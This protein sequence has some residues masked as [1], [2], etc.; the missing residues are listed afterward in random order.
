MSSELLALAKELAGVTSTLAKASHNR[1]TSL[2]DYL[3]KIADCITRTHAALT[4]GE[5]PHEACAELDVYLRKTEDI[6]KDMLPESD[7]KRIYLQLLEVV[8]IRGGE[9]SRMS[10]QFIS[11]DPLDSNE[12]IELQQAAGNLRGL[13]NVLRAPEPFREKWRRFLSRLRRVWDGIT[14]R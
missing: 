10:G 9:I 14:S 8:S 12:L 13:A 1:R 2:A 3:E 7:R 5:K 6:L 11:Y 4:N